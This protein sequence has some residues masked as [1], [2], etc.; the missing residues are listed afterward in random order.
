M[1]S[2]KLSY[3]MIV[4]LVKDELSLIKRGENKVDS[5]HI[6]LLE[7]DGSLGVIRGSVK[8]SMKNEKHQ[9]EIHLKS[10]NSV[11][12]STCTCKR[13]VHP[14]CSH[15]VALLLHGMKHISAT[16]S[17]CSW[18]APKRIEPTTSSVNMIYP[19]RDYEPCEDLRE[20]DRIWFR[21][22]LKK[23]NRYVIIHCKLI[24]R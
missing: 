17:A 5:G 21:E 1:S 8:A 18:R 20:E 13:G 19:S 15:R 24:C 11:D 3:S 14:A 10:D 7:F 12:H 6:L 22:E 23:L 2:Y 9:V 16:D 4:D